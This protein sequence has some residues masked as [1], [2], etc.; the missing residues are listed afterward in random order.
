V[1]RRSRYFWVSSI[2]DPGN[3]PGTLDVIAVN[4]KRDLPNE[5]GRTF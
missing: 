1:R 3:F 4:M 5:D 2:T